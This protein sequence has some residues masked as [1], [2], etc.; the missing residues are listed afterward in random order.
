MRRLLDFRTQETYFAE[1]EKQYTQLLKAEDGPIDFDTWF[2]SLSLDGAGVNASKST[3]KSSMI[4]TNGRSVW[5]EREFSLVLQAMR[6]IR[7]GLVAS[8]RFDTFARDVYMFIIRSTI[9]VNHME[10]YHPALLHLLYR[11]HPAVPLSA[12]ELHEFIGYYI[13]DLACRQADI[14]TAYAV[15]FQNSYTDKRIEAVLKALVH[16]NWWAF[17]KVWEEVDEPQRHLIAYADDRMR[18]CAL[19]CLGKSYLKA[20]KGFVEN[21]SHKE[22]ES[23]K[24]TDDVKWELDHDVVM[25]RRVQRK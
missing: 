15:R 14:R 17:W 5:K 21:A 20:E 9:L 24:K 2:A 7:E 10:S 6:K 22:W 1:I 12:S 3:A 16:G 19:E 11:I 8:A 18:K 23:L 13:L 25:I 4:A